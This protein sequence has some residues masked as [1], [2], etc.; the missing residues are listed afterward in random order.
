MIVF[1]LSN[2]RLGRSGIYRIDDAM[3]DGLYLNARGAEFGP[4]RGTGGLARVGV[5]ARWDL[6][7]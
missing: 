4:M 3:P 6:E 2:H 1:T 7:A 5:K